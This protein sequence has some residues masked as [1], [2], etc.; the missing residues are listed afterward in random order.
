MERL[1]QIIS[2]CNLI[3]TKCD[4][5]KC[6]QR[7]CQRLAVRVHGLVPA[8]QLLQKQGNGNLPPEDITA[9]LDRFQAALEEAK[10]RIDEFK[11]TAKI[12]KFLKSGQNKILFS[13]VNEKLSDAYEALSLLLQADQRMSASSVAGRVSWPQEDQ[14]DTE[15]DMRA[16]QSLRR[17]TENIEASLRQLGSTTKEIR[18][19]L[20]QSLESS[21]GKSPLAR[22]RLKVKNVKAGLAGYDSKTILQLVVVGRQLEPLGKDCL[23]ELR[24]IIDGCRAY[25]PSARPSVDEILKKLEALTKAFTK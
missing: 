5:M 22:S 24:K 8:L 18:E 23:E 15:E 6:C 19:A 25:E 20:K 3:Y 2:L 9:A 16:L 13:E 4:E 7:Q 10:K 1:E 21:S 17:E 12:W 11:D 14:E